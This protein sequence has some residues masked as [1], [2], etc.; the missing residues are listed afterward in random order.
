MHL[1]IR[2]RWRRGREEIFLWRWRRRIKAHRFARFGKGSLIVSPR[3]IL[4]PH[5]I[6]IG[7]GV[8]I[9]E[10][11]MFSLVERYRG[12]EHQPSL[13]IGSGSNIGAGIWLS[14]VG[15][16][17]IG[18]NNLMGHNILIADS[19]HEYR[20]PDTPIIFQP[21]AEPEGVSIGPGCIIGPHA[22]ILAGVS[23]GANSFVAANAVV[24]RSVP[25]NS[26]VVGNPARVIRH[27]DRSRR[28]WVEGSPE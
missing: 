20:D 16:I 28:E 17:D 25:P 3:G 4:S 26:V 1:G 6:E 2:G 27:F 10:G 23:I 7:D 13:R 14:C 22:A 5:R 24:T 8:L 15:Q 19:Y 18:E 11:A 12:R 9:H 21:M